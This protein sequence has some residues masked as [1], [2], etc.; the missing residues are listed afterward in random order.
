M[1]IWSALVRSCSFKN[2]RLGN[3]DLKEYTASD[4]TDHIRHFHKLFKQKKISTFLEFGL[5]KG[6]EY[7]LQHCDHVISVELLCSDD[8]SW[9]EYCQKKLINYPHWKGV[10]VQG[11]DVIA[12]ADR[13]ALEEID[14]SSK[15]SYLDELRLTCD[16]ILAQF[17]LDDLELV[18][19]DPGIHLRGDLVNIMLKKNIPII[20]AHDTKV[21]EKVY[22][23]NR[24]IV[25]SDY[26]AFKFVKGLGL[27][28]WVRK[29]RLDV[30]QL[31]QKTNCKPCHV[32]KR[33]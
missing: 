1:K 33:H 27:T 11:S 20:A 9:F 15:V 12:Q 22:G 19:I 26:Q 24:I 18:F 14:P 6:T 2:M 5:G 8:R 23:W 30:I 25:P 3:P 29:D 10:F 32:R 17:S 28:L 7:F 21:S 31:L 16:K 13:L 4:Y